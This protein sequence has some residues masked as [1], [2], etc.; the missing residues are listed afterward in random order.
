M[1]PRAGLDG[2]KISSPLAFDPGT[3]SPQSVAIP[4]ELP[5]PTFYVTYRTNC[6]GVVYAM[7]S[8]GSEWRRVVRYLKRGINLGVSERREVF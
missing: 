6:I 3:S 7:E 5:G 8:S 2:R 1:G 4:T